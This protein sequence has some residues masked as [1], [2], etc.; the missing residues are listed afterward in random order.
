M[1]CQFS[2]FDKFN[3]I[4]VFVVKLI[5]ISPN[6]RI[7]GDS[8]V[9]RAGSNAKHRINVCDSL[10][11]SCWC[12]CFYVRRGDLYY[13][14]F[15]IHVVEHSKNDGSLLQQFYDLTIFVNVSSTCLLLLFFFIILLYD[16]YYNLLNDC[17]IVTLFQI[18]TNIIR[19]KMCV[20]IFN[21]CRNHVRQK[22]K[23]FLSLR[24]ITWTAFFVLFYACRILCN[25]IN[26]IN[27]WT[28]VAWTITVWAVCCF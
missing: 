11:E 4:F 18:Q 9:E 13:C 2:Q 12:S 26:V 8:L 27:A 5:L 22:L 28:I 10:I 25:S 19:T 1:S 7:M 21:I 24:N 6:Y 17:I 16:L 14:L 15:I 20:T 23:P 3:I